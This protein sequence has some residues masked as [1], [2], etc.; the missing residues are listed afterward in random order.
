M[1]MTMV[2]SILSAFEAKKSPAKCKPKTQSVQFS[3][4]KPWDTLKAQL[5][6]KISIALNPPVIDLAQYNI[7]F[8]IS[9]ILLKPGLPL[10]SQEDFNIMNNRA[11][12]LTMKNPTI[13]VL[14]VEKKN[15]SEKENVD[16]E[17]EE[18]EQRKKKGKKV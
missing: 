10:M 15:S 11:C 2:F 13:N 18:E 12:N 6:A 14:I 7:M 5:L 1:T 4:N 3:T 9:R 8:Y 16:E 17:A